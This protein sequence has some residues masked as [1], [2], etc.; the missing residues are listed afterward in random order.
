MSGMIVFVDYEHAD[1]YADGGGANIQAARTWINYRLEDLSDMHSL[2]VRWDRISAELLAQIDARAIFISGN[3]SDPS[4]YEPEKTK[5]LYD[6]IRTTELPIFGFCGGFQCLAQAL[7]SELTRID[8]APGTPEQ[9]ILTTWGDNYAEYGYY[10]VELTSQHPLLDGLGN[11]PVFRHAHAWHIANPPAGFA[12][13]ARTEITP[14]QM[15]VC[16][17]RRIVGTQFH[18]EYWTDEH[19]AGK[20][21]ITNFMS[22]ADLI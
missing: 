14:V 12:V 13:A 16:D 20:T 22:W 21:L 4:R 8:V 7:G 1:H 5:A 19:P 11:A 15:A 9:G 3:A 17:Q 18:P 2:L 6:I 10:P